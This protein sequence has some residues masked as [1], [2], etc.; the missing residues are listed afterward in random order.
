MRY[1]V[2]M[3]KNLDLT[4]SDILHIA[5][6]A[7]LNLSNEEVEKYLGQLSDILSYIE[8]LNEVDTA[9]ISETSQVTG[10]I[11]VAREDVTMNN[12]TIKKGDFYT[13]K[14]VFDETQ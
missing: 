2:I 3:S 9:K 7:N 1:N 12:R 8:K 11:N 5:K 6:L 4:K 10:L 13:V 14:A